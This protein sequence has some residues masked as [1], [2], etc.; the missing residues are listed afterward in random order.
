MTRPL[1]SPEPPAPGI[2]YVHLD[3]TVAETRELYALISLVYQPQNGH[4][5]ASFADVL[6]DH[7]LDWSTGTPLATAAL[8]IY[9]R[10]RE[11]APSQL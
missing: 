11:L 3:L 4:A 6:A 5:Q 2:A 9:R 8:K 7:G 10:L 1:L